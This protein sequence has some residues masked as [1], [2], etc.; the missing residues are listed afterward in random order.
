MFL[1]LFWI[2]RIQNF[3]SWEFFK[4]S[5]ACPRVGFSIELQ[6][7]YTRVFH[8]PQVQFGTRVFHLN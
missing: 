1:V 2:D 4:I 8:L 3:K 6:G 7:A 5:S